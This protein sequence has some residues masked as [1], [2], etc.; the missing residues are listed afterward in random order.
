MKVS[1]K[2]LII[3]TVFMS[4]LALFVSI[5]QTNIMG[6]MKRAAVWPYVQVGSSFQSNELT[7]DVDNNGVGPAKIQEMHYTFRDSTFSWIHGLVDH[8]EETEKI[9]L[10]QIAYSNLEDGVRVM[11]AEENR[12]I[13]KIKASTAGIDSLRNLLQEVSIYIK[14]CSIYDECWINKDGEIRK[15]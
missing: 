7:I 10:K 14:F 12:Q 15:E 5:R 9:E 3:A 11:K 6:D 1:E 13:L 2:L 8:I 4:I